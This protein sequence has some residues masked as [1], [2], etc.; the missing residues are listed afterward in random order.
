MKL[1]AIGG[2]NV[3]TNASTA[4]RLPFSSRE[5]HIVSSSILFSL[6]IQLPSSSRLFLG[7][8]RDVDDRHVI[9]AKGIYIFWIDKTR[10]RHLRF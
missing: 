7:D 9:S 1:F 4:T 6:D 5:M 10:H 2:H 3:T 8:V